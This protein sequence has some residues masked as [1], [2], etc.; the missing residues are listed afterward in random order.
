MVLALCALLPGLAQ[1]Q[2][3]P[4]RPV[5]IVVPYAPGG[6]TDFMA[7]LVAQ[8]LSTLLGQPVI[9][10]NKPGASTFIGAEAVARSAPDGYTLLIS[11]A[12]TFSINKE[13]YKKLPYDPVADFSPITLL[14]HF[15]LILVVSKDFPAKDVKSFVD[16]AKSKPAGVDFASAGKGSTHHLAMEA[17]MQ[18]AGLRME[19][20]PYKGAGPALQD[21]LAGRVPTMFLDIAVAREPLKAGQIRAL[22]IATA[23]RFPE[24]P[25]IPTLN[26]SGYPGFEA[27]AWNGIVAPKGT[28][29][30]II[31][32]LNQE[33]G[34]AL[35]SPQMLARLHGAGIEAAHTTPAEFAAY[36][37]AETEKWGQVIRRGNVTVEDAK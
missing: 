21:L 15:P 6:G 16:L 3:Y 14:G 20:I 30:A 25:E 24:L 2:S 8:E 28:P 31:D 34:K 19:H 36:I 13:L 4:S 26:E 5:R 37:A 7:R 12:S 17:F 33:I 18:R 1:P 10:D 35:H 22:G 32:R 11:A 29:A 9:I 23:A 27:S